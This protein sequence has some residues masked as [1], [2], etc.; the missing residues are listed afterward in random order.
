MNRL[1]SLTIFFLS[2]TNLKANPSAGS[3]NVPTFKQIYDFQVGDIFLYMTNTFDCSCLPTCC[4]STYYEKYEIMERINNNDSIT[5]V[6]KINDSTNDT[7][8][9][10]DSVSS[11]L[12]KYDNDIVIGKVYSDTVFFRIRRKNDLVPEKI[13][14]GRGHTYLYNN[15]I[16]DTTKLLNDPSFEQIYGQGLGLTHETKSE[17]EHGQATVL[18]GYRK[19]GDTTGTLT[20]GILQL[21]KNDNILI[22][23]NPFTDKL[24][25]KT[26]ERFHLY[27]YEIFTLQGSLVKSIKNAFNLFEISTTDLKSGIYILKISNKE[28]SIYRKIIKQ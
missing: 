28:V 12:N 2:L 8:T 7:I 9:Y 24:F 20:T 21:K 15:G 1:V 26:T 23:P 17:F 3:S 25:V 27:S 14:G 19:G 22:Y 16:C 18:I 4:T 10:V 11:I 5:Y 13:I 6:R